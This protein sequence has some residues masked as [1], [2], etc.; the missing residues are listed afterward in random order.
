VFDC[1]QGAISDFMLADETGPIF[2]H[3]SV[4]RFALA[5]FESGNPVAGLLIN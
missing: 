1:Y 4:D 5:G 2:A 3:C